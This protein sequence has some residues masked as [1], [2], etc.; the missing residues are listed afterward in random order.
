MVSQL[1]TISYKSFKGCWTNWS[2]V[3]KK[4][5][6]TQGET[7]SPPCQQ[8]AWRRW[9][10][11]AICLGTTVW[12]VKNTGIPPLARFLLPR[13][14]LLRFL[15]YVRSNVFNQ[16]WIRSLEDSTG[17]PPL[18]QFST[19]FQNTMVIFGHFSVWVLDQLFEG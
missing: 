16:I 9:L 12:T 7:G 5:R 2:K 3:R 10:L 17:S 19:V 11:P 4:K 1:K 6:R 13:I 15:A 18:T 8:L 14:P